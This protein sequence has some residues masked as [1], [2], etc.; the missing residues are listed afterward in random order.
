[1][2]DRDGDGIDGAGIDGDGVSGHHGRGRGANGV[3][4]SIVGDR[5]D[6]YGVHGHRA[7]GDGG[8]VDG[9]GA[10]VHCAIGVDDNDV[11]GDWVDQSGGGIDLLGLWGVLCN[12]AE[13]QGLI[14]LRRPVEPYRFV[15]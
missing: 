4:C 1:M 11:A 5:V 3:D 10:H 15:L 6:G 9:G 14:D 13:A 12:R 2:A 7:G 8:R